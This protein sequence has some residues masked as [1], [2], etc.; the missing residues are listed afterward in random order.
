MKVVRTAEPSGYERIR[1]FLLTWIVKSGGE[2][3]R[4]ASAREIAAEFGVTH[5]T[6]VRV[7]KDLEREGYINIKKGVGVFTNPRFAAC[8]KGAKTIAILFGDGRTTFLPR[9]HVQLSLNFVDALLARSPRFQAQNCFLSSKNADAAEEIANLGY[10]G[11]MWFNPVKERI[12]SV[13]R[14]KNEFGLAVLTAPCEIK[15]V[16][17]V[18]LELQGN[19]TSMKLLIGMGRKRLLWIVPEDGSFDEFREPY[20]K[21]LRSAGLETSGPMF[22]KDSESVRNSFAEI[23][24]SLNPD[25]I[26]F[27]V[28]I[29]DYWEAIKSNPGT[30][31][32][33]LF[34]S[35]EWTVFKDMEGYRG[36]LAKPKIREAAEKGVDDFIDQLEGRA[37]EPLTQELEVEYEFIGMERP[38]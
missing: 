7:I 1:R 37:C 31:Q 17:S 28:S 38:S 20:F 14:L 36:I 29:I 13:K 27:S 35:G 16:S 3:M 9:M 18:A 30:F 12:P 26:I 10:D 4:L 6:V 15:G 24:R 2:P 32:K 22:L 25:A 8:K 34:S 33:T 23:S 21:A 11:V 19:F 5:T